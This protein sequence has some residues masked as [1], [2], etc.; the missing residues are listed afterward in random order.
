M[1]I[2][3]SY[4]AAEVV[5]GSCHFIKFDDGTKV[6]VDCGMFQGLDEWKNYE[7]LGFDAR[8]IDYLLLTHAHLDHVGRVPLLYKEGFR[9]K[10]VATQPTFDL[11]KIVLLDTAHVMQEEFD[12]LFRK[13][14]R[15]GEE[16]QV[17][18][19]LYDKNDVKAALKLPK[20]V[21]K[22][23]KPLKL[24][25][26]IT[27]TYKDAGHIIGSAFLEISYK[28][29][30]IDKK[31][32]FSGDLGNRQ[33]PLN[34]PPVDPSWSENVFIES[35]YGDRLHKPYEASVQEFKEAILTTLHRDGNVLIPSFA[36][37]RTQQ[38]L[39]ILHQMSAK[40]EFPHG[41]KVFLDTPMGIRT[42]RVY[43][44]YKYLLSDYCKNLEDPFTFPELI[45]TSSSNA[46]KRINER[47]S[48]N[49]II[50]GSG[51][52]N[53]GR[54]LHHFKHRIWNP[55][56]SVIIVGYQAEG[57][58]GRELVNGARFIHVYGEKIIVKA[59]LYTING[60]SAHADQSELLAWLGKVHGLKTAFLI[61]G[62]EDKQIIFKK[63]I[64]KKLH[65]KAHIVKPGEIIHL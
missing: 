20:R 49:I 11:A 7:P 31:V 8:E 32:I 21:A 39:C 61:H 30:A 13:A 44:K 38:L 27:V 17:K 24:N 12:T 28:D 18:H 60:F 33:I 47:K 15:R 37:E 52:C 53:G 48:R 6:L 54:I 58:L 65:K 41:T 46:S 34:P 1:T 64:I 36:I 19:P 55:R 59:K 45:F 35:T 22:Y 62:E 9:G 14:Q 2:E 63:A 23:S 4:G 57:T 56:N 3:I 5:T 51:M 25:K 10:I 29:G 42:T 26:N 40:R 16:D 50:A 43:K